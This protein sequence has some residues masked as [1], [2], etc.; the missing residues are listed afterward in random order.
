MV[1]AARSSYLY[2]LSR[3]AFVD[4]PFTEQSKSTETIVNISGSLLAIRCDI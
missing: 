1:I 3:Y 4:L 2:V